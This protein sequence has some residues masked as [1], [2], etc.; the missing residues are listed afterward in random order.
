MQAAPAGKEGEGPFL[1]SK[2]SNQVVVE[3]ELLLMCIY[4][5]VCVCVFCVCECVVCVRTCV[6]VC[7]CVFVCVCVCVCVHCMCMLVLDIIICT[8]PPPTQFL[9]LHEHLTHV[10]ISSQTGENMKVDIFVDLDGKPMPNVRFLRAGRE[11]REDSRIVISTNKSKGKS[12]LEI[13]KARMQ[14]E[15]K[16]TVNLE[17]DG[18]VTDSATFSVFIKG[19]VVVTL[20]D[21]FMLT[22]SV[23][24]LL[25]SLASPLS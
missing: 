3:G 20:E 14:D 15:A 16:Y 6:Y 18:V 21:T 17:Q 11:L 5:C 7:V 4:M 10:P 19:I 1:K 9:P 25:L 13:K 22:R 2:P 24:C 8:L 12:T 23:I